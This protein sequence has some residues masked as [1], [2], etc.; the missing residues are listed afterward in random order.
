MDTNATALQIPDNFQ[1][2]LIKSQKSWRLP[3][4]GLLA[5]AVTILVNVQLNLTRYLRISALIFV[6]L[7]ITALYFRIP[8]PLLDGRNSDLTTAVQQ[9]NQAWTW[10]WIAW[11]ALYVVLALQELWRIVLDT[12]C[13]SL[14]LN[15]CTPET[16][17]AIESNSRV[18]GISIIVA[19]LMNNL[20]TLALLK[21]YDQVRPNQAS[22]PLTWQDGAVI[23]MVMTTLEAIVTVL[24]RTRPGNGLAVTSVPQAFAGLSGLCAGVALALLVGRLDSRLIGLPVWTVILMYIYAVLQT[25]WLLF[26]EHA[27]WKIVLVIVALIL[28]TFL[29]FVM[30]WLYKSGVLFYYLER[31]R[32]PP[33]ESDRTDSLLA[34]QTQHL[35]KHENEECHPSVQ[36]NN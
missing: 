26:P 36:I 17:V 32:K 1:D 4:I 21:C 19:N 10:L 28:K 5:I 16:L 2:W 3:S 23:I 18:F 9:F 7:V 20:Q 12:N 30:T 15:W 11:V 31:I 33:N 34:L 22:R 29:F 25:D 14:P 24:M 8:K 6:V 27:N 35:T 13:R